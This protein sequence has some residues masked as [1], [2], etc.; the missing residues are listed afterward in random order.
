MSTDENG[1]ITS[2]IEHFKLGYHAAARFISER[3]FLR[4]VRLV[5]TAVVEAS[6]LGRSRGGRFPRQC[7]RQ[8][9]EESR[10][11]P[12][13]LAEGSGR[14]LAASRRDYRVKGF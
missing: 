7:D 3:N 8:F 14:P 12:V 4:L 11:R 6:A 5:R 1:T 9:L 2:W 13:P 10:E